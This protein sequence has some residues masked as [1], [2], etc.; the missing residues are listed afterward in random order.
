MCPGKGSQQSWTE[1]CRTGSGTQHQA[2]EC[3]PPDSVTRMAAST[4]DLHSGVTNQSP[5]MQSSEEI[6]QAVGTRRKETV[7]WGGLHRVLAAK[8]EGYPRPEGGDAVAKRQVVGVHRSKGHTGAGDARP[9]EGSAR[10]N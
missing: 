6:T 9:S 2:G 5:V 7:A 8:R 4:L 3:G 10:Q 1:S